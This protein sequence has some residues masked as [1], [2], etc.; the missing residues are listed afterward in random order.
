MET[1]QQAIAQAVSVRLTRMGHTRSW[2]ATEIGM[3]L[4]SLS[5]RLTGRTAIDTADIDRIAGALGMTGFDLIELAAEEQR[6]GAA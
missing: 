1:T 5:N 6:V 3:N 4:A 2:L